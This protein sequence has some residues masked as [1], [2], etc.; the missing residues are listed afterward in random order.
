MNSMS[1]QYFHT[2]ATQYTDCGLWGALTLSINTRDLKP[3][4][5]GSC[6][7]RSSLRKNFLVY[8]DLIDIVV[9]TESFVR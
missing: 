5:K 4:L 3:Q 6:R 9:P 7:F 1:P 8:Y 2:T